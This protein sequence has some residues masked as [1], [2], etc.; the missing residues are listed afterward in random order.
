MKGNETFALKGW[1]IGLFIFENNNEMHD[2]VCTQT[3]SR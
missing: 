1:I 3:A 2:K